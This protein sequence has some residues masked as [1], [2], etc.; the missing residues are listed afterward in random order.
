M[1][2]IGFHLFQHNGI[3]YEAGDGMIQTGDLIYN[4]SGGKEVCTW[5]E[6]FDEMEF[7]DNE[8]QLFA[9]GELQIFKN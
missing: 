8:Q 9:D 2:V 4:N 3:Q 6:E 1:T 7:S 5:S